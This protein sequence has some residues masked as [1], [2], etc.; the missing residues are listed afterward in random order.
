[1]FSTCLSTPLHVGQ[2]EEC[3]WLP[4]NSSKQKQTAPP[5]ARSNQMD[6]LHRV[7]AQLLSCTAATSNWCRLCRV[8]A[9]FISN[10][11]FCHYWGWS[12][13]DCLE[14]I[15]VLL[16]PC[17]EEAWCDPCAT[18]KSGRSQRLPEAEG[19]SSTN[20]SKGFLKKARLAMEEN[21]GSKA[22]I[23]ESCSPPFPWLLGSFHSIGPAATGNN[24]KSG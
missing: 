14:N 13:S 21:Y 18:A 3:Q 24:S 19:P 6:I 17:P 23:R 22:K 5:V 1:M 11:S 8:V 9:P 20:S 4:S 7:K 15:G 2:E 10:L 12:W 16:S